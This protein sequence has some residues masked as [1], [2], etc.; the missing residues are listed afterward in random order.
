[1]KNC[2]ACGRPFASSNPNDEI[3]YP[4]H[5]ALD[6]LRG[7]AAPIRRGRWIKAECSEK[8]G[9]ANCSACGHFDWDDCKYCSACGS[10]NKEE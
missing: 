10:L 2:K 5:H 3:C 6:R 8:N 7:Y 1:M 4:C 9:N